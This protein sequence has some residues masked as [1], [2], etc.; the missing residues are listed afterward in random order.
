[1]PVRYFIPISNINESLNM[2]RQETI[3]VSEQLL[4]EDQGFEGLFK[5]LNVIESLDEMAY[6]HIN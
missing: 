1:M 2:K 3:D 5:D 6:E 4:P